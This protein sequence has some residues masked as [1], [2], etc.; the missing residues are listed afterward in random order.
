[1]KYALVSFKKTILH[2][3]CFLCITM[4][5]ALF[6]LRSIYQDQIN[7]NEYTLLNVLLSFKTSELVRMNLSLD[8]FLQSSTGGWGVLFAPILAIFPTM[9]IHTQN[10]A[11]GFS[12]QLIIRC[13]KRVF[14]LSEL[15][16]CCVVSGLILFTAFLLFAAFICALFFIRSSNSTPAE[17]ALF[18]PLSRE[19]ILT[20]LSLSVRFFLWGFL[21]GAFPCVLAALTND[22]YLI[23]SVPF[24]LRYLLEQFI[25]NKIGMTIVDPVTGKMSKIKMFLVNTCAPE[26]LLYITRESPYLPYAILI[27]VLFFIICALTFYLILN[28]RFDCGE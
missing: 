25:Y 3:S 9:L 11:S 19:I 23:L 4:L 6:L 14:S 15:I 26:G 28:R 5:L 10:R 16:V 1:M 18:D 8:L 7:G 20:I 24:H 12:R 22:L 21:L 13:K 27:H 2:P 17:I